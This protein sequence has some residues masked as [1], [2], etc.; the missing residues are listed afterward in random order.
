MW[1]NTHFLSRPRVVYARQTNRMP[2]PV[3][4]GSR[5]GPQ[6]R[7]GS[8][9]PGNQVVTDYTD[10]RYHRSVVDRQNQEGRSTTVV[11]VDEQRVGQRR[12]E[13]QRQR[14]VCAAVPAW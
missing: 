1:A 14:R 6:H 4:D 10:T 8:V 5:A 2:M 11:G 9:S 13:I 7:T 12:A 3:V